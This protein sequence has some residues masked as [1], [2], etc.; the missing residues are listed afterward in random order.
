MNPVTA[1]FSGPAAASDDIPR[2]RKAAQEFEGFLLASLLRSLEESL[3]SVPGQ[4]SEAGHDEYRFMGTQALASAVA[5]AGGLGIADLIVRYLHS[6]PRAGTKV[7][8]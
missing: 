7:P 5:E 6:K 2:I 3:S 8:T 1:A 4:D